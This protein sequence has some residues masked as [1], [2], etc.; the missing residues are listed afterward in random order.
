MKSK[1]M[2]YNLDNDTCTWQ[3]YILTANVIC[4][5][6]QPDCRKSLSLAGSNK[7]DLSKPINFL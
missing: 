6:K 5:K 1:V 4:C 3:I 2:D 7:D